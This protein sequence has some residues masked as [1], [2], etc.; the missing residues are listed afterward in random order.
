VFLRL[1]TANDKEQVAAFDWFA[2]HHDWIIEPG[3][4]RGVQLI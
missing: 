2:A 4:A 3:W 1:P